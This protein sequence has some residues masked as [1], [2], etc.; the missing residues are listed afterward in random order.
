MLCEYIINQE[1]GEMSGGHD[2]KAAIYKGMKSQHMLSH[3]YREPEFLHL[4]M[5]EHV[6]RISHSVCSILLWH[7]SKNSIEHL[8]L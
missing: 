5:Q 3:W 1:D 7:P 8:L 4:E 2:Y 6:Y